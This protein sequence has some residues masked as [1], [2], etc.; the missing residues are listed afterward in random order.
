MF[1]KA[2]VFGGVLATAAALVFATAG[3]VQAQHHGGGGGHGGGYHGGGGYGGYHGG[4]YGGY[5]GGGYGG[6][7]GGGYHYGGYSGGYH[8]YPQRG[9]YYGG[10]HY[11]PYYGGYYNPYYATPYYYG[12]YPSYGYY[13]SYPSTG[14]DAP[15]YWSG[16]AGTDYY[17]DVTPPYSGAY[18]SSTESFSTV[19]PNAA[20]TPADSSAHIT[21]KLPADAAL[22]F[23]G[24]RTASTGT[25]REF[26]TPSLAPGRYSYDVQARWQE[27]GHTVTQQKQVLVAPG[28]RVELDFPVQQVNQGPAAAAK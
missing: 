7:H 26:T 18:D 23:N 1:R 12:A 3:P 25:V 9:G 21:V 22:T 6:Y 13:G 19:A 8:Y 28:A 17:G 27:D 5:H 2:L 20:A 4:G 10:H 24:F 14:Y 15:Y 16:S 11:H